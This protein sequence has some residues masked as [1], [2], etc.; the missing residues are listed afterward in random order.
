MKGKEVS[1]QSGREQPTR[2]RARRRVTSIR[3][4]FTATVVG[5]IAV[6]VLGV[7][8]VAERNT[9][10]ALTAE[11][12]TRLLLE[13]RNLALLSVDALLTEYP[14]LVLYPAVSEMLQERPDLSFAYVLDHRKVIQGHADARLL[15]TTFRWPGD[16][17]AQPSGLELGPGESLLGNEEMLV[18]AV[19]VTHPN[20]QTVGL[21]IVGLQ[22]S[23]FKNTMKRA[24]YELAGV[25]AILLA[26][27][28]AA[29]LLLITF[30][31][32]PIGALRKG[33]ERIGQ[34]DLDTPMHLRDRTELGLLADTVND[35]A[36]NLKSAREESRRKE[37]EIIDT[38]K[39]V[40]YTLGG[41]VGQRSKETGDH[42]VRVGEY[43][44]LLGRLAGLS[45]AEAE[46]LRMAAPMHDVGKVG[47]PDAVLNKPGSLT[48]EEFDQ[49]KTHTIIGYQILHKSQRSILK[50]A[51]IIA[52]EH[53]E[54]WDGS[55]YPRGLKGEEIHI[56][57]RIV[58]LVDVFDALTCDRVY[59][60]ASAN[61]KVLEHILQMRGEHFDP[62]LVDLFLAYI[63][64][65]LA[66]RE[67][68]RPLS[69]RSPEDKHMELTPEP[70][71]V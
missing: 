29:A 43:S 27:G 24:R 40:I 10:E 17:V 6:T 47:I 25:T 41:V 54:R 33:L 48:D 66:I 4:I 14:E 1:R 51:A 55:G 46:I 15:G 12:E 64:E 9:R 19:P 20:G 28:I 65:F 37:L 26:A 56:F 38:Q 21:A 8:S 2:P 44:A 52:L 13:A 57:G 22:R 49:M 62:R 3:W 60:T 39:E 23:Y 11:T 16:F 67:K 68:H 50:S 31:M 70:V 45:D 5:L 59:R 7:S 53:H 34:G 63:S 71:L 35:M 30:L 61:D 32:R 42:I 58:G 36:I 69:T 18:A